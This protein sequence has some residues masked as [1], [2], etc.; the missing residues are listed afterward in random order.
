[1]WYSGRI[2]GVTQPKDL[3][4]DKL[5]QWLREALKD[6][7]A[8]IA[9]SL[10]SAID[11]GKLKASPLRREFDDQI[12][13]E[14]TH[15]FYDDLV[16]RLEERGHHPG[17]HMEGWAGDEATIS[18]LLCEDLVYFR[19]VRRSDWRALTKIEEQRRD[20]RYG[21]L[22]EAQELSEIRAALKAKTN[23]IAHL[24][25]KLAEHRSGRSER[26]DRPI[27]TRQRRTLLTVIAALCSQ[28][29]IDYDARGAAQRIKRA[30][31]LLGAP[32][33]DG[34]LDSILKEIPDALETRMKE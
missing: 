33:D 34:T 7:F 20:A 1:M 4:G 25:S 3:E 23:Q 22:N 30:T 14:A 27:H 6:A 32:I 8:E 31:E 28:S 18:E 11:K 10:C 5:E 9:Q 16:E 12:V 21:R 19:A 15:I 17:D 26:V 2:E 24:E 13:Q 29:G